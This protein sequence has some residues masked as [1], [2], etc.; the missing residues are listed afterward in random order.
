MLPEHWIHP[1]A[2]CVLQALAY[3]H[4]MG[5]VHKDVHPGNVFVSDTRGVMASPN[6]ATVFKI[7]DLGI[8]RLAPEIDVFNTILAKWMLPPEAIRPEA[9]GQ[10]GPQIDIYHAGL[11]FLSLMT[12]EIPTFSEDEILAGVPRQVAEGL[13]SPYG[14]AISRAL[15][16]HVAQR[17]PNALQFWREISDVTYG[18]RRTAG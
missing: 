11:T 17:T 10:I 5:Y 1:I 8:S 14:P 18:L 9:F 16:R 6:P 15:R 12:K 3:I 2:Q 4:S 7:G 13:A